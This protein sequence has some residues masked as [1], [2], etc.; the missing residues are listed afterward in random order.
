MTLTRRH[1]LSGAAVAATGLVYPA[2]AHPSRDIITESKVSLYNAYRPQ[3]IAAEMG[4]DIF[5]R[6]ASYVG[7]RLKCLVDVSGSIAENENIQEYTLQKYGI[8]AALRSEEVKAAIQSQGGIAFSL[9]EFHNQPLPRIPWALLQSEEDVDV[10]S[11]LVQN[12][13]I[14]YDRKGTGIAGGLASALTDF[15]TCIHTGARSVLDVSGDGADNESAYSYI[16]GNEEVIIP[17]YMAVSNAA[18]RLWQAGVTCNAI[19]LPTDNNSNLPP[20]I[21]TVEEYYR[22]FVITPRNTTFTDEFGFASPLR[23]GFTMSVNRWEDFQAAMT[24]KLRL[25]I[26]GQRPPQFLPRTLPT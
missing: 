6:P 18:E 25:E 20:G 9:T 7:V 11:N 17:E 13:P 4:S 26:I 14:F 15:Q 1:F 12:M 23:A 8:A 3:Q 21:A 10:M 24:E 22:R 19:A 2:I 5:M 16:D